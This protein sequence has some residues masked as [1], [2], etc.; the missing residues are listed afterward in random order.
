MK[1]LIISLLLL[2]L[3]C[4]AAYADWMNGGGG[5][6]V[7]LPVSAANGGTGLTTSG[8][9]ASYFLSSD[10]AGGFVMRGEG[11]FT[12]PQF[13]NVTGISCV[14]QQ[15]IVSSPDGDYL[16]ET[17]AITATGEAS[18][19]KISVA[20]GAVT[21]AE[22]TEIK[23]TEG[24]MV[25]PDGLYVYALAGVDFWKI[26][27]SD[28][29]VVQHSTLA[30]AC[31][32]TAAGSQ[33]YDLSP[34]GATI[35]YSSQA[36]QKVYLIN[37][38]T[39]AVTDITADN[40]AGANNIS[41]LCFY[42]D[43]TTLYVSYALTKELDKYSTAG[44]YDSS[45]DTAN[46]TP[47]YSMLRSGLNGTIWAIAPNQNYLVAVE[48]DETTVHVLA[49]TDDVLAISPD[50]TSFI[51]TN[52]ATDIC[53]VLVNGAAARAQVLLFHQDF[54]TLSTVP[55]PPALTYLAPPNGIALISDGSQRIA[56]GTQESD[57]V[58]WTVP[59]A[60]V[61]STFYQSLN[62]ETNG[63]GITFARGAT[64]LDSATNQI[65]LTG[66]LIATT[67]VTAYGSIIGS[68]GVFSSGAIGSTNNV[69]Y[70]YVQH[71]SGGAS[72]AILIQEGSSTGKY[73]EC[74]G[75]G[76]AVK[77][78]WEN[79]GSIS[80]ANVG[81]GT[82][83]KS[84]AN[85]LVFSGTIGAGGNVTVN[86]T[87]IDANDIVIVTCVDAVPTAV[88]EDFASRVNATSISIVGTVGATF[89]G[90]IQKVD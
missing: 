9:D 29:S 87:A 6:G 8:L 79:D 10:G 48:N 26:Q 77:A 57:C 3:L 81:L 74:L 39:Y 82:R 41:G 4:P 68:S 32:A 52:D 53:A 56:L 70:L 7:S 21:L 23:E 90:I 19:A 71:N 86:T 55:T 36:D 89:Q 34:N 27:T 33:P 11:P 45:I 75:S 63:T 17:G 20:T 2:C 15:V 18:V 51:A 67:D 88:G 38:T 28:M 69:G 80:F 13:T 62:L 16:Y 46:G 24:L 49:T 83:L 14:S 64:L 54:N 12:P 42:L 44:V 30:V 22:L 76:S 31:G 61:P 25:S 78:S 85:G 60:P 40:S 47:T 50:N 66:A 84:G 58:L 59:G 73:L 37:T 35:A 72:D 1:P 5:G 65:T 43:S